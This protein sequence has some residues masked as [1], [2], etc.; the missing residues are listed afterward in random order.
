MKVKVV[1]VVMIPDLNSPISAAACKYTGMVFVPPDSIYCHM[2]GVVR[3][4]ELGAVVLAALVYFPFL[5]THEEQILY[6]LMEIKT[7]TTS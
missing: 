7:C 3:V 4:K 5:C 1:P 6:T 2:M